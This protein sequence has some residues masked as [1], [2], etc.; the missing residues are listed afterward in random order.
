MASRFIKTLKA[1]FQ[2]D[3][4]E[5]LNFFLYQCLLRV[6]LFRFFTSTVSRNRPLDNNLFIPVWFNFWPNKET[7]FAES[8]T[9]TEIIEQADEI[10]GCKFWLFGMIESA[11]DLSP[12][13]QLCHWSQSISPLVGSEKQDIKFIWEPARF[14][15]AI[16][17]AQAFHLTNEEKYAQF[18]W[19]KY[20]EFI[21]TNPLNRGPN[22]ESAQEVALRL[23][24]LIISINLIKDAKSST[25]KREM[26][27][28][29]SI[30]DHADRIPPTI[31]YAK[32]QNNN[33]LISEAVG[34]FTAGIFL[35]EHPHA[36]KWKRLGLKWF[37]KGVNNQI[38]EDGEYI[39]HSNNYQRMVLMLA[40][41]MKVLLQYNDHKIDSQAYT[42]LSHAS[43]WLM[44]QLDPISGQV[45]NLGHNDGSRILP[46]CSTSYSDYRPI[47]QAACRV[48]LDEPALDPG[49][50]DDLCIWLGIPAKKKKKNKSIFLVNPSTPRIG[51]SDAW[52]S[53]RTAR[54]TSRP[55][56]AD[57]LHVDLWYHGHNIALD[58]GTFQYNAPPPWNN[59]LAQTLVHNTLIINEKDQMY[60]AGRFLWLDWAQSKIVDQGNNLICAEHNGY[61]KLRAV[62]RRTLKRLSN[63][64]WGVEDLIFS[65]YS[66]KDKYRIDLHWLLPNWP[67]RIA[68][69]TC[70]LFAPFGSVILHISSDIEPNNCQFII[71]KEGRPIS[72]NAQEEPLLGWFSP[73][74]GQKIPALSIRY[75]ITHALPITITSQFT[76]SQ[77]N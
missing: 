42:K 10:L 77:I 63:Q 57:Q 70:T 38:S 43:N 5:N 53:L 58:A 47:I 56:H 36:D 35:P 45:P 72:G 51:N 6:G 23:V 65:P 52:A 1:V 29:K 50:W 30:A 68:G 75:S 15:W 17:L 62:H 54:Y 44:C 19:K 27:L 24:A 21:K 67:M 46:F 20:A 25:V 40:L 60:R 8:T 11:I 26:D 3:L 33:H 66:S 74:Y 34:L 59:G 32:A 13:T 41:W 55:A 31:F 7:I 69:N 16:K 37:Y 14:S 71:Y 39:Q 28:F 22:W 49:P 76:F 61:Q 48:F 12:K 2:L 4:S 73:T 9:T 64:K 18:F